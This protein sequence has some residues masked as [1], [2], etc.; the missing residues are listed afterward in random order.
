ML[1]PE[2]AAAPARGAAF[3]EVVRALELVARAG[4]PPLATETVGG[5]L[6]QLAEGTTNRNSCT[7]THDW[8]GGDLGASIAAVEARYR[9]AGTPS[10]FKIVP[11]TR[12][13]ELDAMLA[14]R[15]YRE[16]TPSHVLVARNSEVHE[17]LS[18]VGGPA[19]TIDST[20]DDEWLETCW[21]KPAALLEMN[22][23]VLA[24]L[25]GPAAFAMARDADGSAAGTALG[26]ICGN[27]C[28]VSA[29]QVSPSHR[30][31]GAARALMAAIARWAMRQGAEGSM[32]QVER[33]NVGA[34]ALYAGAG[35]HHVYDYWYRVRP[36]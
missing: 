13:S 34:K 15:G 22:A 10:R 18:P 20:F 33:S 19:I 8:Q 7:L 9:A 32:L 29:V 28:Y 14:A 35:Y 21:Q 5:W 24:R 16:V 17:L 11:G 26:V 23:R 25:E 4:W 36:S 2:K 6:L 3:G 1:S 27:W 30:R 31:K 12:P